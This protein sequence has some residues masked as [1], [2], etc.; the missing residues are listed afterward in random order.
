MLKTLCHYAIGV[1]SKP[2]PEMLKLAKRFDFDALELNIGEIADLV[3]KSGAPAV[4]KMFADAG[5]QSGGWGLPV[6]WRSSDENWKR[7]L[8][9]LP[10]LAKAA[11]DIG[12]PRTFT[13]IWCC[14]NERTFDANYRFHVE[15]FKPIAQI[16][17][18]YGCRLGLEFLGPKTLRDAGKY[19]FIHTMHAMLAMGKEIGPN[20]G[21]LLD[22]WHWYTSHA[23]IEDLKALRPEQIVYVHVNDAPV[24]I[25]IDQQIDDRRALP[26]ETGIVDIGG[27]LK[28]LQ[29]IG[30]KGPITAEPFKKE[31]NSLES[32]EA[33]LRTVSESM[34][35]IVGVL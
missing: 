35:K 22:C 4:K 10:R 13:Y 27:F 29:S 30:Y 2:L 32:D 23:T 21:L 11:A 34:K 25:D 8:A 26:G 14:S 24:G 31:L 16:L 18:E 5:V 19:P 20:T 28:A 33:R 9:K 1:Q 6:D 17:G 15:R 12:C 7:D 3:D